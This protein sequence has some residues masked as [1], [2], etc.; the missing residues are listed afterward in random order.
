MSKLQLTEMPVAKTGM[1]IRKPVEEVFAVFIE[2]C[3][4]LS[5]A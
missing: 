5:G 3:A 1:L 2:R 4:P